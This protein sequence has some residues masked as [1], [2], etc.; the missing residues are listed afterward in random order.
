MARFRDTGAQDDTE[1]SVDISPLIDV[2]FI[3]LIF[4]IVA[5]TF[6]EE[7]GIQA[8]TPQAAPDSASQENESLVFV[9][10]ADGQVL[11]EGKDIGVS[12]VR[13]MVENQLQRKAV[14]VIIQSAP[15]ATTG[16][17]VRLVDEAR[18]AGAENVSVAPRRGAG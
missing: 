11:H 4:F 13:P 12:G 1:T 6:V 14:P 9:L 7:S 18:L 10:T 3:L 17:M 2:V 8:R 16:Q 15:S 5:T